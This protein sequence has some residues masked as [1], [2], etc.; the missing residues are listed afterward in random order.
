MVS[1][2]LVHDACHHPGWSVCL[3]HL[4]HLCESMFKEKI[5]LHPVD[6][7]LVCVFGIFRVKVP[8]SFRDAGVSLFLLP[9]GSKKDFLAGE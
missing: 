7:L 2:V 9:E 5:F 1:P 4:N 8:L 6:M 3:T